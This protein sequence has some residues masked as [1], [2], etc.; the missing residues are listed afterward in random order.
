MNTA[1]PAT[2][3]ARLPGVAEAQGVTSMADAQSANRTV[4]ATEL[5][6]LSHH[7]AWVDRTGSS[8]PGQELL[9]SPAGQAAVIQ[10]L[11]WG[12]YVG[13]SVSVLIDRPIYLATI[14]ILLIT[15]YIYGLAA[16]AAWTRMRPGSVYNPNDL[17]FVLL[18]PALNEE[19]VIGKTIASLLGLHGNFRVLVID[20]ASDDGTVAAVTPF[21]DDPRVQLLEQP[22]EQARWGKGHALNAGYATVQRSELVEPYG[23]EN[24]IL[25]V[26]DSDARVESNFLQAIAPHFRDPNV[27]GVQ[28]EVRMYNAHQNLLTLWQNLEFM[29]WGTIVCRAKSHLGSATLGGNGQCVRLSALASLGPEPWR[30]SSLTEDL[31]ISLRLLAK[32]QQMRFCP[33]ASVWQEAVPEI[34]KLVRQ[35]SRWIQGQMVCWQHLP[36]L[37]RS[38]LPIYTRLDLLLFL[39]LP[40]AIVPIGLASVRTW[41]TF[42]LGL[43]SW[44][45]LN[46]LAWYALGFMVAP[47]AVVSLRTDD[48]RSLWQSVVQG[49]LFVFYSFIWFLA[50]IAAC[51][52]VL[53]G[54]RAWAKTSRIP[55]EAG[56]APLSASRGEADSA[57][58]LIDA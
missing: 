10:P 35:R 37:L 26:F 30:A 14:L 41:S 45:A 48:H 24:V 53:R 16:I 1:V 4:Q 2:I 3:L 8:F 54:R 42:L 56:A 58:R 49:H 5:A 29:I 36:D 15:L 13:Y 43:G 50:G 40:A 21:L 25:V 39:L 7:A 22:S 6:R 51:W 9:L 46:L 12:E 47:L 18:V 11:D 33:S 17:L 52:N 55:T 38:R 23:A 28:S 44:D 32:G 19:R 31:D 34:G 20:D 57:K 27:V